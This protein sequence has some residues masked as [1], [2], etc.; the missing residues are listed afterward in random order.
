MVRNLLVFSICVLLSILKCN[1]QDEI[2]A[3]IIQI[4]NGK[5]YLDVT[6][7]N[8]KKGDVF[9]V[10]STAGY[11]IHPVTKK[12][13]PK[14]GEIL[15]DLEVSE[16]HSEYSIASIYP[17]SAI[18]K[19][20]V[21]MYASMPE[22]AIVETETLSGT[23]EMS[24]SPIV[25]KNEVTL[26]AGTIVPLQAVSSVRASKVEKGQSIEFRVTR[27]I[28]V[29]GELIIPAGMIV[30]GKVYQAKKSKW[31]G[32][33]GRLGIKIDY[34]E[35]PSGQN[36]PLTSSDIYITGKNRTALSVITSFFFTPCLFICG[37]KAEMPAGYH[38]DAMVANSITI[39][40]D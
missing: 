25:E 21:G 30:K 15:A 6:A 37:S 31:V 2:K 24:Y 7:P 10:R 23:S 20:K 28:V 11:M 12:K 22:V 39:S 16:I 3:C 36:V 38:V 32:T 1:A 33:K 19:L 4:E 35:L 18:S 17:E 27:G 9:S 13:I 29:D 8:A 40:I 26:Q 34:L 14:E 5:V